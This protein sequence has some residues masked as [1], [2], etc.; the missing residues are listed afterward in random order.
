MVLAAPN[1]F[2]EQAQQQMVALRGL[3]GAGL[4]QHGGHHHNGKREEW[5][6]EGMHRVRSGPMQKGGHSDVIPSI[7]PGLMRVAGRGHAAAPCC[8]AP[9]V[10]APGGPN[11]AGRRSRAELMLP[12]STP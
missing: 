5:P 3:I 7:G 8:A 6:G 2:I 9:G 1:K 4:P 12:S 11:A 10:Y